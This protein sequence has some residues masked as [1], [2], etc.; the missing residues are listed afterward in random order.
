M[1]I[2]IGVT[3]RITAA[4]GYLEE[5]DTLAQAWGEFLSA[6][7]PEALWMPLPNLAPDRIV[8]YCMA[9]GINRLILSGGDNIGATPKRDAA[10]IGL[11]DWAEAFG[12]PVLGICRG[13]QVM[14][15]RDGI[16]ATPRLGHI[17]VRHSL[18]GERSGEVN[19]FHGLAL[20]AIPADYHILAKAADGSIEA[21]RHNHLPWEGWMWHPERETP[22]DPHDINRL[23][24]LFA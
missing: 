3:S 16:D 8:A 6:A 2:R 9:W 5:R 21:M 19:S 17:A 10:E 20:C 1:T 12:L 4:Q 22:I 15:H 7:L 18:T 23:K 24:I 11:L 14:A 13:M